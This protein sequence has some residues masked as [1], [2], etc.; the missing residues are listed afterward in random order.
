MCF[1]FVSSLICERCCIDHSSGRKI[2]VPVYLIQSRVSFREIRG[3]V[4]KMCTAEAVH[5]E[6][7]NG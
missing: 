4:T 5:F 2:Q 1:I 6:V 7:E 3:G